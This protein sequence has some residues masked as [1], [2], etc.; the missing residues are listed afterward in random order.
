[1]NLLQQSAVS[2]MERF[3]R[4]IQN[5]ARRILRG[6]HVSAMLVRCDIDPRRF[7]LMMDLFDQLSQRGEILDQLGRDGVALQSAAWLYGALTGVMAVFMVVAGVAPGTYLITFLAV[8]AFLLLTILLSEAGNSLVNPTEGLILAHQAINGATYTAAKLTHLARIVLYLVPA[9]NGIP[10]VA[11]LFLART[12]WFYPFLHLSAALGIG[13]LAA[14][15]CCAAYGWLI[16]LVPA[17]RLKVVGQMTASL[18]FFAGIWAG[19]IAKT[20]ARAT[21][22]LPSN[23]AARWAL[24]AA[25]VAGSFAVVAA[26]IRALSADYLLHVS[27]IVHGHARRTAAPR[28]SRTGGLVARIFGGQPARAGFVFV[29]R[30]T[31][32]DYNFRRQAIPAAVMLMIGFIP[33]VAKSWR[34]DPF[35]RQ[36]STAHLIPHLL[37]LTLFFVCSFLP[38]GND[39]KGAW[40]FLAAPSRAFHGFS[41]GIYAALL[42]PL[43]LIP[44]ALMLAVFPWS[45]GLWHT[46]LFVAYSAAASSVYLAL[47]L[48]IIDAVPFS[49]Q[50]DSTRGAAMM[51]LMIAGGISIAV[52]V[53]LQYL[54]VFLSPAVTAAVTAGVLAVAYFLTRGSLAALEASMRYSL[55]LLSMESGT[56]YKEVH[57]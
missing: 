27:T 19:S 41:R 15:L 14:L 21:V 37:G 38:Y 56:L 46:L 17:N 50:A 35:S 45:W 29:G 12:P 2:K 25:A 24:A 44:H 34:T 8:T 16:R 40:I 54:L 51:P 13:L 18:P 36:F 31:R 57:A 10:A 7:W 9:I 23:P 55:G 33:A 28:S 52:A 20:L 1:M 30:M 3:L 5:A 22:L 11:A 6:P 4:P 42:L 53:G 47:D 49:R 26:G 39:Y 43:L 48:R 32:V